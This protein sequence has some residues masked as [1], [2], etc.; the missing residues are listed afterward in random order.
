MAAAVSLGYSVYQQSI[1]SIV[2]RVEV[3]TPVEA[4]R[5]TVAILGSSFGS[6]LPNGLTVAPDKR[7]IIV[8]MTLE[9][10]SSESSNLYGD[11][12][13][14]ANV[15]DAPKPQYYLVRDHAILWDLQPRMPETVAAVW[16]VPAAMDRPEGLEIH[17]EGSFFKP[18]DNLYAAPGWFPAGVVA[19][20]DLPLTDEPAGS[21]P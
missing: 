19:K 13:V 3:A 10:I 7:A 1:G 4:G 2:P 21:T 12:I 20:M 14:L 5:W 11:L 9:N 16:E 17:I 8:D 15:A 6:T 18:R